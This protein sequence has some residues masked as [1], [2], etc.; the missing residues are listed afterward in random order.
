MRGPVDLGAPA[1]KPG[2]TTDGDPEDGARI[3]LCRHGI[4]TATD[5]ER[6]V[7]RAADRSDEERD[8]LLSLL[9]G[10]SPVPRLRL[11]LDAM[12]DDEWLA[13]VRN[14]RESNS[15]G[16]VVHSVR[17]FAQVATRESSLPSSRGGAGA[18]RTEPAANGKTPRLARRVAAPT[19][20]G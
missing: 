2:D 20:A 4:R 5:L 10:P 7:A 18:A 8:R 14:W 11:V 3:Y 13:Y 15:A 1:P 16:A 12:E 19:A 9:P 6:A 17:E